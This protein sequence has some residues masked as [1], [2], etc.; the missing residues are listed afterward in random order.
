MSFT[1]YY[2]IRDHNS[3]LLSITFSKEEAEKYKEYCKNIYGFWSN[4]DYVEIVERKVKPLPM[5]LIEN[6]I[7]L[8]RWP[9]SH[10]T[11]NY[12]DKMFSVIDFH[13]K[14]FIE[15]NKDIGEIFEINNALYIYHYSATKALSLLR[16]Y[17]KQHEVNKGDV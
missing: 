8:F 7:Y 10:I 1:V 14:N 4:F 9:I 15:E 3:E 13:D 17:I 2:E 5:N 11:K 16:S 6:K 12:D